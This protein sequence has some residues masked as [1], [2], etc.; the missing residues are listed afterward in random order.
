LLPRLL[1]FLH[2]LDRFLKEKGVNCYWLTIRAM[3]K[4]DAYDVVRWHTD[5]IFFD[6]E[7]EQNRTDPPTMVPNKHQKSRASVREKIRDLSPR[8]KKKEHIKVDKCKYWKLATTLLGPSTLFLRDG[9]RARESLRAAKLAEQR[10]RGPHTCRTFRCL[11]CL[12]AIE[13]IRYN[14]AKELGQEA[15][16][17]PARGE[18]AFFRL[19]DEDGAVHSEPPVTED[20]IF[21]NVVPGT[22]DELTRLMGRWGLGFPRAWCFGV[23]AAFGNGLEGDVITNDGGMMPP[24]TQRNGV[25]TIADF[26]AEGLQ[27]APQAT[28]MSL[29]LEERYSEWLEEKGFLFAKVFG[30]GHKDPGGEC[31][32][33][34][35]Q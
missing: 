5:D 15:T 20:R 26:E 21:V 25:C 10:V 31:G 19:G 27:G 4:T 17:Q 6:V 16:A 29:N 3:K 32:K 12:D 11:S 35:L 18:V 1:P 7:G 28:S 24:Q 13:S 30:L 9:D 33:R 14:L 2:F 34:Q 22:E 23:P 8:R